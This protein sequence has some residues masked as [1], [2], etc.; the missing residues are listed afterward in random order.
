MVPTWT[1]A[2]C[3]FLLRKRRRAHEPRKAGF[4]GRDPHHQKEKRPQARKERLP[5]LLWPPSQSTS[6]SSP[7]QGSNLEKRGELAQAAPWMPQIAGEAFLLPPG[8]KGQR[9]WRALLV[10]PTLPDP[11]AK[12]EAPE[13]TFSPQLLN[14]CNAWPSLKNISSKGQRHF[15]FFTYRSAR[16]HGVW[17]IKLGGGFGGVIVGKKIFF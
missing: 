2:F 8:Q 15:F 7:Y 1:P 5:Q 10:P 9:V 14:I 3:P 4:G 16:C 11:A 17:K 13:T 12:R 6:I